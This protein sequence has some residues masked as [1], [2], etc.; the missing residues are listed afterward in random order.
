[1]QKLDAE[2]TSPGVSTNSVEL[3]WSRTSGCQELS[4]GEVRGGEWTL[5]TRTVE[6]TPPAPRVA[7][8]PEGGQGGGG[9]V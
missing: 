7:E 2:A 3:I 9:R 8:Q 4:R 5:T 1:M 6:T